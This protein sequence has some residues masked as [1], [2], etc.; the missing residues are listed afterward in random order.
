MKHQYLPVPVFFALPEFGDVNI[1]PDIVTLLHTHAPKH[2]GVFE[3]TRHDVAHGAKAQIF[4]DLPVTK[5][6]TYLHRLQFLLQ[7]F[8]QIIAFVTCG[9]IEFPHEEGS[10]DR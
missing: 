4:I 2:S 3:V 7:I 10:P 9:A 8:E 6:I 1:S 5:V